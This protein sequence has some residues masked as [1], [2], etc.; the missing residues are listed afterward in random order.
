MFEQQQQFI[1]LHDKGSFDPKLWLS[2]SDLSS[3][4]HSSSSSSHPH[5]PGPIGPNGSGSNNKFDKVLYKNLVEMVPLVQSLM[6]QERRVN[7]S[8]TRRASL[9][10]TK[11]PSRESH[12]KKGET[13]GRKGAQSIPTKKRGDGDEFSHSTLRASVAEKDKEMAS[14]QEQVDYLQNKLLEK[15]ELLKSAD[16]SI[17]QMHS[18]DTKLE[19]LKRQVAEKETLIKSINLQLSDAKIKLADRQ[20]ALEKSRWEAATSS[21][22][23]EKLQEEIDSMHQEVSAFML[24]LETLASNDSSTY[25]EDFDVASYGL[26]PIPYIDEMDETM[27]Q[28]M[29]EAREAYIAAIAIAKENQDEESLAI[30]AEARLRLQAFVLNQ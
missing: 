16:A 11:T 25:T 4:P 10:Y 22:K 30:A 5:L 24:L 20:A 27:M 14:L 2:G 7:A 9:I 8:Y 26:D 28:Q 21:R 18:L 23:V 12:L 6:D 1:D 13:K 3:P 29:E 19:E 15:D 17:N